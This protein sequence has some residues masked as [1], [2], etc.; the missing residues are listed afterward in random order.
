MFW[1]SKINVGNEVIPKRNSLVYSS[2]LGGRMIGIGLKPLQFY[3][4]SLNI[5]Q[6]PLA[7]VFQDAQKSILIATEQLAIKSMEIARSDLAGFLGVSTSEK[8]INAVASYDGAYQ[9]RAGTS[10]GGHSRYCF[11]SCDSVNIA[12]V[13]SY[14]VSCNS[15]SQCSKYENKLSDEK[16][17]SDEFIAWQSNHQTI[18]PAP[19]SELASVHLESAIA[20]KVI[21]NALD[22]GIK[23]SGLVCDGDHKSHEVLNAA[24]IYE[25]LENP[26]ILR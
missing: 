17:T 9:Q 19:F 6:P 24:N 20:P 16:I 3:H 12:K 8:Y 10:G 4:A 13:L 14:E 18:C 2:I 22:R 21:K 11:S 26:E 25:G 15:C 1:S 23:F 7:S 5:P